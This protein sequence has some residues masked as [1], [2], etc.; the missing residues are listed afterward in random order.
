MPRVAK[1]YKNLCLTE[2]TWDR[3]VKDYRVWAKDRGRSPRVGERVGAH[4]A[5]IADLLDAWE[6]HVLPEGFESSGL[7]SETFRRIAASHETCGGGEAHVRAE[8]YLVLFLEAWEL[9]Q[10]GPDHDSRRSTPVRKGV[11]RANRR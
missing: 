6:I 7:N 2:A 4:D 11:A 10:P 3:Y 8:S 5:F 1:Q 9:T